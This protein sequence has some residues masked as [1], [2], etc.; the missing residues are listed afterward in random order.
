MAS[1]SSTTMF[2]GNSRYA[3]DFQSVID[4]AVAIASLPLQQY[5][6]QKS[7][8]QAESAEMGVLTSKFLAMG[9]AVDALS[10]AA[11]GANR[12]ATS[13]DP[14]VLTATATAA[15]DEA[16]YTLD[17]RDAGS[18]AVAMSGSASVTDPSSAGLSVSTRFTLT[19]KDDPGTA[20]EK[21]RTFSFA[22]A[23]TSLND[24]RDAINSQ[25]DLHA[26]AT[27]VN[28]GTAGAP[29][30]RL[31]IQS[32]DLCPQTLQLNDGTT[33][34]LTGQAAGSRVIYRLNGGTQDF[35]SDSRSLALSTGL[36][37]NI[38]SA[39]PGSPIAVSVA[40]DDSAVQ[41]ALAGFA[42]VYN[43]TVD[44]IEKNHG[45]GGGALTGNA[46]I[47]SLSS[48]LHNLMFYQSGG[49]SL[50]QIGLALDK[51]GHVSLDSNTFDE[52][53]KDL[54]GLT[55]FLG[56]PTDGFVASA[57]SALD[58]VTGFSGFLTSA[59]DILQTDM[60]VQDDLISDNQ[61]RID[62]LRTSLESKM[63]AADALI[64]QLEQ[65]ASYMNTMFQAM[66]QSSG[67]K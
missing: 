29:D 44:E 6:N 21:T 12:T 16:A 47:T 52:A 40:Q 62:Q 65:Q 23:G 27:I 35:T 63:A 48:V 32:T 54:S 66:Q 30:Y 11:T 51:N 5:Q 43:A 37:V 13:S 38:L 46:V 42:S 28:V 50:T 17:I 3:Q 9:S 41:S 10:K 1:T 19:V 67:N 58:G 59:S 15:A 22:T 18:V 33:D 7:T 25:N 31:S 20:Q 34:L 57:K 36:T 61:D 55:R 49:L 8:L 26:R 24:L 56:S 53:S 2:S 60:K 45:S 64:A 14:S 4:R 39:R